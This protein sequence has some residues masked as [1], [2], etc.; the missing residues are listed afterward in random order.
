MFD[1][2]PLRPMVSTRAFAKWG[3]EFVGPIKPPAKNTHAEYILVA[4]DYLT[5]WVEAKSTQKNDA[6]T[7]TIFPYEQIFTRFGLPIEIMSDRGT[8]FINEV[9]QYLLDELL[10]IHY[11]VG[12]MH[13]KVWP[14]TWWNI[15]HTVHSLVEIR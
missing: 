7:M 10:V 9:I 4:T 1:R 8:H 2:M 11:D 12:K 5:K 14:S 15:V 6:R 3:L 13:T